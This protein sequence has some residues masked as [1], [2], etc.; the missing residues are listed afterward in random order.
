MSN[1]AGQE[2]AASRG[3]DPPAAVSSRLVFRHLLPIALAGESDAGATLTSSPEAF[4]PG[5]SHRPYTGAIR[6]HRVPL[7]PF[8]SRPIRAAL[9]LSQD[10]ALGCVLPHPSPG[11]P[12]RLKCSGVFPSGCVFQLSLG[13]L[14]TRSSP[15]RLGFLWG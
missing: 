6:G 13:P 4:P 2:G 1:A 15:L 5:P 10:L 12:G 14:G 9:A 8:L 7:M 11:R 3:R